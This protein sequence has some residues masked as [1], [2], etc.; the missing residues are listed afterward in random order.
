MISHQRVASLLLPPPSA[1]LRLPFPRPQ[2]CPADRRLRPRPL[3][4]RAV[5]PFHPLHR[6]QPGL[7]GSANLRARRAC[8]VSRSGNTASRRRGQ[9]DWQIHL[10]IRI[11]RGYDSIFLAGTGYGKSLVF[12]AVA[13]LGGKN[14]VTIIICPLKAL[15]ADQVR[16]LC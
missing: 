15:E 12:E 6:A 16:T 13:V 5:A 2:T 7:R 3:A 10:I 11:L 4:R 14:K 8:K 1:H 9:W